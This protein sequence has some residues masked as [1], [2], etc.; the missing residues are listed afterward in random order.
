MASYWSLRCSSCAMAWSSIPIAFRMLTRP[1][2]ILKILEEEE[3]SGLCWHGISFRCE[4]RT[5]RR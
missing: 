2:G 4:P 3:I 1:S 5:M